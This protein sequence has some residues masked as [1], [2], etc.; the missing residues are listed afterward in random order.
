M[1]SDEIP[2]AVPH[3]GEIEDQLQALREELAQTRDKYLR[4]LAESEN[5]RKR[6]ERL[7]ED[8]VWQEKKRLLNYLL[9]VGDQLESALRYAEED[10]PLGAG[11]QITHEQLKKM[12]QLEGVESVPSVG[13]PFDPSIHEAV[14]VSEEQNGTPDHVTAEFR[15]GYRLN[16]RLLRPARVQVAGEE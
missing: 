6:I 10:D 15:S 16:G 12:L 7:C 5:T 8:R 3:S 4:A 9:D 14:E 11:I 13:Y 1:N 2:G